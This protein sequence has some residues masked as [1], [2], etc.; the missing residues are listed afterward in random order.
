MKDFKTKQTTKRVLRITAIVSAIISLLFVFRS[1]YKH[2]VY[3]LKYKE[4]VVRYCKEYCLEPCLVFAVIKTESGFDNFSESSKGA[5]GL[6]QI[7]PST[8]RYIANVLHVEEYDLFEPETNIRFGC[9]YFRYLLN[10]FKDYKT[11]L[12]S[13]NAGE[14]NVCAWLSEKSLSKDGKSLDFIPY[15]ETRE[16]VQRVEKSFAKYKKYYGK[17]LDK[18]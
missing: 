18:Y 11:T 6:M 2:T 1:V 4:T 3:P 10:K 7:I 15:K 5:R 8:A 9:Y 17:L 14:G 16:Y 12:C 13:Y